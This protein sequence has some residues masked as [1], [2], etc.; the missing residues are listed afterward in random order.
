MTELPKREHGFTLLEMIVVLILVGIMAVIAGMG[1]A[2][3]VNGYFFTRNN[4]AT[5]QKGQ[6][7]M[8]R[9]ARE[10]NGITSASSPSGS[11]W[12]FT[13]VRQG[14]SGDHT[15]SWSGN[16][17]RLDND[18]LCDQVVAFDLTFLDTFNGSGY[19][20]W[21]GSRRI[22]EARLQLRGADNIPTTFT[23]RVAPRNL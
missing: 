16:V 9:L 19:T 23:T 2:S 18:I 10:M 6:L 20:S 14:V 8:A 7:A 17:L 13:S 22:I 5:A 15:I 11:S 21:S 12:T 1:I 4:T 3:G